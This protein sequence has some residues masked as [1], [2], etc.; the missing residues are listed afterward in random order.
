MD[1]ERDLNIFLVCKDNYVRIISRLDCIIENFEN[2]KEIDTYNCVSDQE[3]LLY[4]VN[5]Q[6]DINFFIKKRSEINEKLDLCRKNIKNICKHQYVNDV[7]DIDPERSQYIT[8]CVIC[9]DTL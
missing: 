2:I 6:E 1:C 3:L 4:F 8:Y 5:C 9:N 7:I